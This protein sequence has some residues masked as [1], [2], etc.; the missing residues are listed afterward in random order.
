[1]MKVK[2]STI[3]TITI[4]AFLVFMVVSLFIYQTPSAKTGNFGQYSYSPYFTESM[5]NLNTRDVLG[6]V[7]PGMVK[8]YNQNNLNLANGHTSP[9]RDD[10]KKVE[11]LQMKNTQTNRGFMWTPDGPVSWSEGPSSYDP[12]KSVMTIS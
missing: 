1:M 6:G 11:G 9:H 10:K 4:V 8:L 7:D 2:N 3:I 12:S 5:G